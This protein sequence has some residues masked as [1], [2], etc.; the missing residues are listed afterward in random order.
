MECPQAKD[1]EDSHQIWKITVN[2]L[3]KQSRTDDKGWPLSV[4]V[5]WRD[6]RSSLQKLYML[7]NGWKI[8][9]NTGIL[10]LV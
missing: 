5:G 6:H 4:V 10:D 8:P 9:W 1:G 2:I 3:N 7:Q